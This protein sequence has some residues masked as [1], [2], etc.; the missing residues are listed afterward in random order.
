M[1][2]DLDLP[3]TW[4]DWDTQRV[5][6]KFSWDSESG[7]VSGPDAGRVRA[8]VAEHARYPNSTAPHRMEPECWPITDPLHDPVEMAALLGYYWVLP[9]E[10]EKFYP[11][12]E[13]DTPEGRG[14]LMAGVR[15][16]VDDSAVTN[17]LRRL[18]ARTNNLRPLMD[19]IG[20]ELTVST[21]ARFASQTDPDGAPWTPLSKRYLSSKTKRKSRGRDLIL[22]LTGALRHIPHYQAD[23]DSVA[24]GTDSLYGATQQFGRGLIPARPFLGLSTTDRSTIL[25]LVEDHLARAIEP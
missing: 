4:P 9:S 25:A 16:T 17:A 1:K 3:L 2:F 13:D 10:L 18:M 6:L 23:N 19:E 22:V 24:I 20:E 15:I 5:P 7:T 21:K 14:Q 11:I 12:I 8:M